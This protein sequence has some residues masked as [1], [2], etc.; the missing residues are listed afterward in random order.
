MFTGG[1]RIAET[2]RGSNKNSF[3]KE[4]R[5]PIR[6]SS[7][8]C[9]YFRSSKKQNRTTLDLTKKKDLLWTPCS[10]DI[11]LNFIIISNN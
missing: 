5:V 3:T 9:K 7:G 2:H 6:N 10:E 11:L 4:I 8:Y 1:A